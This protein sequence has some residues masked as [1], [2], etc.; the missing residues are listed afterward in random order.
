MD[1]SAIIFLVLLN[2]WLEIYIQ[3]VFLKME[4]I[5]SMSY[6]DFA[7]LKMDITALKTN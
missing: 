4:I 3:I 6:K 5:A 2:V 7:L 1:Q